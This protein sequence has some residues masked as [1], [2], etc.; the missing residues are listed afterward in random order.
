MRVSSVTVPSCIGTFKSVR[1]RTR[2]P[3]RSPASVFH[4][5]RERLGRK[6]CSLLAAQLPNRLK[7]FLLE[8]KNSEYFNLEE[9][10]NRVGARTGVRYGEAVHRSRVV[11]DE[12]KKA[13]S[14]GEINDVLSHLPG[15]YEELFGRKPRSALSPTV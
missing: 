10:Y 1:I 11:M 9:F 4:T 6:E 3:L 2:F 8:E 12:L 15:E 7:P 13:I 14:Q 5:L